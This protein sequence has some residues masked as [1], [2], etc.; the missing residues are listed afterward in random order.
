MTGRFVMQKFMP[1]SFYERTMEKFC[2]YCNAKL[3]IKERFDKKRNEKIIC[4]NCGQDI[5]G[6]IIIIE[7]NKFKKKLLLKR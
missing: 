4:Q 6:D 5:V 1:K 7:G 2:P 3:T